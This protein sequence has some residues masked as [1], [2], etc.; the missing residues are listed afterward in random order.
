MNFISKYYAIIIC[1]SCA[2]F[3]TVNVQ[4]Q[5]RKEQMEAKIDSVLSLLTLEE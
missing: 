3:T 2:I 5:E 4:S 1:F